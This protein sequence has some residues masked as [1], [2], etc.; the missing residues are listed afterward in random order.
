[1]PHVTAKLSCALLMT[2]S[3]PTAD[4]ACATPRARIKPGIASVDSR[5]ISEHTNRRSMSVKPDSLF[6]VAVLFMAIVHPGHFSAA[7]P[8]FDR[9][10]S[11][12]MPAQRQAPKAIASPKLVLPNN[13]GFAAAASRL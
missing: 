9:S 2:R 10:K 12:G 5:P 4:A 13:L 1:D 6:T 8:L 7:L 11:V 3:V